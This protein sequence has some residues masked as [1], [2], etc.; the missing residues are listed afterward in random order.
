ME[1]MLVPKADIDWASA[2][3]NCLKRTGLPEI[4]LFSCMNE[5]GNATELNLSMPSQRKHSTQLP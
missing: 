3:R 2:S 1:A 4:E 5:L